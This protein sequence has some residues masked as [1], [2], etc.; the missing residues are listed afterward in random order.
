MDEKENMERM[1]YLQ[2]L[3]FEESKDELIKLMKI[4]LDKVI[5]EKIQRREKAD[6]IIKGVL[7]KLKKVNSFKEWDSVLI[8]SVKQVEGLKFE[9]DKP[10]IKIIDIEL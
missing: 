6:N 7:P 3:P 10:N 5:L 9:R 2:S 1:E 8:D 4:E